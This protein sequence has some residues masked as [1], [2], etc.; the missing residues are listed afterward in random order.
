MHTK[1][2]FTINSKILASLQFDAPRH[3]HFIFILENWFP[4]QGERAHS[5]NLKKIQFQS[6]LN[7][8]HFCSSFFFCLQGQ[9]KLCGSY[10]LLQFCFSFFVRL[11]GQ[12]ERLVHGQTELFG[13][14]IIIQSRSSF[15]FCLHGQPEVF[16]SDHFSSLCFLSNNTSLQSFESG[17]ALFLMV[18]CF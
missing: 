5:L 1:C 11:H 13:S 15:F 2:S 8:I 10:H 3:T 12:L 16:V 18:F 6:K 14:C 7:P 9:S 4:L 17:Q